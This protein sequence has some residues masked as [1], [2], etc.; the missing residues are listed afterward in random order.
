[1]KKTKSESCFAVHK[2]QSREQQQQ[3][4]QGEEGKRTVKLNEVMADA[5]NSRA[6]RDL[7]LD[8]ASLAGLH[9]V[10]L[11]DGEQRDA[12]NGDDDGEDTESPSEAD[13]LV[14]VLGGLGTGKGS[15]D[16]RRGGE[17]VCQGTVA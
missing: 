12:D 11:Q 4:Q 1:M 3:Q 8:Q 5:L 10:P 9:L 15:D 2:N 13:L 14:K 17:G 16:V 7:T 6:T